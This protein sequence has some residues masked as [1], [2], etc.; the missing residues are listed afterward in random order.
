M[1]AKITQELLEAYFNG[2]CTDKERKIVEMWLAD[3][4]QSEEQADMMERIFDRIEVLADEQTFD[5]LRT[6]SAQI[7]RQQHSPF[8]R[9]AM[10]VGYAAA[11]VVLG[12][13]AYFGIAESGIVPTNV[14]E[15]QVA[16]LEAYAPCGETRR[17]ELPDGSVITLAADSRL[18]YP[19]SF[20]GATRNATL[21][22]ECYASIAKNPEKPFVL[23]AGNI[24]IVVKGTQFNVKS[25]NDISESE[26]ALVE[27]SVI[28]EN[29]TAKGSGEIALVP[30]QLVKIDNSTGESEVS[31]FCTDLYTPDIENKSLT[32]VNERLCDIAKSL[33]RTFGVRIEIADNTLAAERFYASFVNGETLEQILSTFNA[34]GT[35]RIARDNSTIRISANK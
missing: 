6:V 17:V 14:A 21:V 27:G 22:G 15:V 2:T 4:E 24:N 16:M 33:E 28:V 34:A 23:S 18:T 30:G 13:A 3:E 7:R 32:Y 12:A 9:W 11:V 1:H 19:A 26:V 20:D 29:K 31:Q 25:Y 8:R 10:R 35:M 5:A